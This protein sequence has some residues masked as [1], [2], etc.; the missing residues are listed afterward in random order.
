VTGTPSLALDS[1]AGA[2]A[3]YV[4]GSGTNTLTFTYVVSSGDTSA[5]LDYDSV[6][7]LTGTI[8]DAANNAAALG[9]RVTA[10]GLVGRDETGRR[11]LA[12]LP[13]RISHSGFLRPRDYRTPVKTRILAGGVHSAKQ[14]VVRIDRITNGAPAER[15]NILPNFSFNL[16]MGTGRLGIASAVNLIFFPLLILV[17]LGLSRRL[18]AA[19][20]S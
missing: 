7:S 6:N 13:D 18:L 2:E 11:L 1:G 17:I 19:R 10:V 5:D 15:T 20:A 16:A 14:Q 8:K 4:S 3:T 12:S 9:A